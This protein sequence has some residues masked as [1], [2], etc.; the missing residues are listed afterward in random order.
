MMDFNLPEMRVDLDGDGLLNYLRET[1]QVET[2][3]WGNHIV[4][5]DINEIIEGVTRNIGITIVGVK[6]VE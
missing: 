3:L 4:T 6:G 5:A 2:T 1:G